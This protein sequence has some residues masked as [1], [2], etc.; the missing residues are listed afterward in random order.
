MVIVKKANEKW[1]VCIDYIDI[2]KTCPKDSY[3]LSRID[4][5]LDATSGYQLLF[6]MDA[7]LGCNWIRM[8]P[9]DEKKITF[10]T[11]KDFFCCWIMF[12]DLKNV[13]Q[14]T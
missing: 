6:F 8:V 7:F 4:Q 10:T 13:G 5:I 2:N 12:F 1:H 14:P 11:D 3:P 9:E